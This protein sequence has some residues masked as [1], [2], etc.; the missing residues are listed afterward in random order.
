MKILRRLLG[1]FVMIAGLIGL[2]LSIAG[3]VGL[4]L[5]RPVGCEFSGFHSRHPHNQY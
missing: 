3:L 4:Y 5:V 2:L 1:V